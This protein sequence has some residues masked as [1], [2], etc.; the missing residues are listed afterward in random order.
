MNTKRIFTWGSFILIIALITWGMISASKKADREARGVA[1]VDK[2][3]E[4]DHMRGATSSPVILIEYS[5]FQ[6]PACAAY[7]PMVEKMVSENADKLTFVYRHFPLTQQHPNAIPS[8][9]A[10]EAAGKQGKFWEMYELLFINQKNWAESKTAKI[11]FESY[12]KD[13]KLDMEK[14][15][16]DLE[17]KETTDKITADQKSG[18]KAK[19]DSTPTF[20]IN[21][22][23]IKNPQNN[24]QFKKLIE[25]AALARKA[26]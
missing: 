1:S 20:Y 19:V 24:E 23:K 18:Y 25:D 16:I 13:L 2:V 3:V 5:D 9:K 17:S 14:Y 12:A 10:A 26:S 4:T 15:A 8:A 7:F 11:I 21:G 6:C 22:Q